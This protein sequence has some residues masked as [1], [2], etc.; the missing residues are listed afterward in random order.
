MPTHKLQRNFKENNLHKMNTTVNFERESKKGN[1]R[2]DA[3]EVICVECKQK[4]ILPFKPRRPE[5]YCNACFKKRGPIR[6]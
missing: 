1:S 3:T 6:R 5:V 2:K 4:F